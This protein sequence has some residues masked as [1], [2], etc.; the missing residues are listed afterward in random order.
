MAFHSSILIFYHSETHHQIKNSFLGKSDNKITLSFIFKLE[1]AIIYLDN[2]IR[3]HQLHVRL[4]H[5]EKSEES[6]KLYWVACS[7]T[8]YSAVMQGIK[9]T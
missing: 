8:W 7:F 3:F 1:I 9:V 4:H 5:T 6:T 2:N